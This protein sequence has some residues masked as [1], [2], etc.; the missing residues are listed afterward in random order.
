MSQSLIALSEARQ[1]LNIT[2]L[3]QESADQLRARLRGWYQ[4]A[5][6]A[7]FIVQVQL[8]AEI[9]GTNDSGIYTFTDAGSV[10]D[11]DKPIVIVFD[12]QRLTLVVTVGEREVC[13]NQTPGG[14]RLMPG[15]WIRRIVKLIE[16]AEAAQRA[17]AER[18]KLGEHHSILTLFAEG[19][20]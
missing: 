6:S 1:G 16:Q 3:A 19:D 7:N 11:G 8:L 20:D 18:E 10:V 4:E 5:L 14:E 13:N 17:A 2:A 9:N 15:G 12:R